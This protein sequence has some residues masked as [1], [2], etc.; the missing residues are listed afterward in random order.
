MTV[1]KTTVLVLDS[2]EPELL[3][4]FYAELLGATAGPA[5]GDGELLL[6]TGRGG[7]VLGVRRDPDHAPPSWPLPEGSQQ[8]HLC[9]LVDEKSLDEAE[10]EA[11]TL[12]ARPVAAEDDGSLPGSRTTLRRYADPAGH[13]FALAA[14][15]EDIVPGDTP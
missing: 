6:V 14:I 10:R 1:P 8:A 5:P 7:L 4:R 11:V 9:I 13:A 3:A 2:A 15:R 12:G